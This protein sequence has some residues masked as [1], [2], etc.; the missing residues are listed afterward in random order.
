MI[1]GLWHRVLHPCRSP[2]WPGFAWP[3]RCNIPTGIRG[4]LVSGPPQD[5]AAAIPPLS[6]PM[7]RGQAKGSRA[8]LIPQSFGKNLAPNASDFRHHGATKYRF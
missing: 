8:R 6:R 5:V 3:I 4:A 1:V 7:D 2:S